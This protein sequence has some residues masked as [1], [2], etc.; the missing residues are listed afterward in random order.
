MNEITIN[1]GITPTESETNHNAAIAS[2]RDRFKIAPDVISRTVADVAD[3]H[4]RE[5][6]W[7][8]A[9][10]RMKNISCGE[11]GQLLRQKNGDPYSD[12]SVYQ[13][14]IGRREEGSLKNFSEAVRELRR[15]VEETAPASSSR[16]VV[17]EITRQIFGSCER[18]LKRHKIAFV[19]GRS[20][21]GKTTAVSEYAQLHNHGETILVRMPTRGT[22]GDFLSELAIRVGL[23]VEQKHTHL[24]RRLIECFDERTLLIVDECHQCLSG[25]YSDRSLASLEFCREI[26]DRRRCGLVMCG[27][28]V[29]RQGLM[30]SKVLRQLWLRGYR[31]LRIDDN[32][33]QST[34]ADFARA[35][36][37]EPAVNEDVEVRITNPEEGQ[38]S[39]L[40]HNPLK[41]ESDTVRVYGLGR[42]VSILEDA[43]EMASESRKPISWGY[44]IRAW[45]QFEAVQANG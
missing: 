9:Y 14:F 43:E 8:A 21:I 34:L 26:Y 44:V 38:K 29:F 12:D 19:F 27:T 18:A 11:L 10:C 32:V 30:G 3:E 41:I 6:K 31:P 1:R 23:S 25:H 39:R 42:W 40:V 20:Q 15:R 16:F 13:V 17:T 37:L 7:A 45:S 28:D 2:T 4:R 36:G 35:H 5:I 22:L 33:S 24:R